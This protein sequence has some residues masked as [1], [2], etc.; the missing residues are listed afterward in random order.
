MMG[1]VP[2]SFCCGSSDMMKR[3]KRGEKKKWWMKKG[4]K[5]W[6]MRMSFG[7]AKKEQEA[8]TQSPILSCLHNH[9]LLGMIN[10]HQYLWI[11]I[12]YFHHVCEI[13]SNSFCRLD[14]WP[15]LSPCLILLCCT[16]GNFWWFLQHPFSC[17]VTNSADTLHPMFFQFQNVF[18]EH[19]HE[20]LQ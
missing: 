15:S 4:E 3:E 8:I 6:K 20:S 12:F 13:N 7:K 1:E 11:S 16:L 18:K 19:L 2:K 9:K 14:Q 10:H 17:H 5:I